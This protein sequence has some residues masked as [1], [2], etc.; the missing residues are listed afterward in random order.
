[1]SVAQRAIGILA[2]GGSLPRE[3]AEQLELPESLRTQMH[4]RGYYGTLNHNAKAVYQRYFGWYDGNPAN[5][6]PLVLAAEALWDAG[7]T[8]VC[9]AGNLGCITQI[10][11]GTG[12]PVV[13]TVELLDWA[14]GGPLPTGL[15]A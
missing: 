11:A 9:A 6:D 2:G 13:H 5:L 14:T 15:D 4:A 1:M 7:V 12:L 3:I 8:V 10:A